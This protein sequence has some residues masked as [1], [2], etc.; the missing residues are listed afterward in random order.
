MTDRFTDDEVAAFVRSGQKALEINKL[1]P[2]AIKEAETR[3][4]PLNEIAPFV[5]VTQCPICFC[6]HKV[7]GTGVDSQAWRALEMARQY[8]TG[9][10]EISRA[11]GDEVIAAIDAALGE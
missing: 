1:Q 3:A 4:Y 7:T 5:N 11:N 10:P 9:V 2:L 6:L 8:I